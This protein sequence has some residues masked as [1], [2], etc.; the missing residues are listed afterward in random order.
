MESNGPVVSN[1]S[2]PSP[3]DLIICTGIAITCIAITLL[4]GPRLAL[5]V[6]GLVLVAAGALRARSE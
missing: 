2:G 4:W 5:L 3:A 1:T 6:L